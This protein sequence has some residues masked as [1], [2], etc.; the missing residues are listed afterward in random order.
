MHRLTGTDL[1]FTD[2][3]RGILKN[4][5]RDI[6]L[7]SKITVVEYNIHHSELPSRQSNR[8]FFKEKLEEVG[9][10]WKMD[11]SSAHCSTFYHQD[12]EFRYCGLLRKPKNFIVFKSYL[13]YRRFNITSSR[14]FDN[15]EVI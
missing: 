1:I 3:V 11:P 9:G 14:L 12:R 15:Y 5:L 10:V 8:H 7:I 2:S 4:N 13:N 6:S